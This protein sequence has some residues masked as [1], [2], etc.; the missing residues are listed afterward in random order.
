MP[1]HCVTRFKKDL[2]AFLAMNTAMDIDQAIPV[3][4]AGSNPCIALGCH[5]QVHQNCDSDVD[6]PEGPDICLVMAV[7]HAGYVGV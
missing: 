3:A 2:L 4:A 5:E 6:V 7:H 1:V